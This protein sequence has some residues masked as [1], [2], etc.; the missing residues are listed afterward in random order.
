[1]SLC[2]H[3]RANGLRAIPRFGRDHV[4][5]HG[6]CASVGAISTGV[7]CPSGVT[8]YVTRY[9][10]NATSATPESA[11]QVTT[12]SGRRSPTL[13]RGLLNVGFALAA[14]LLWSMPSS[15][16]FAESTTNQP[17]KRCSCVSIRYPTV[18]SAEISCFLQLL[19]TPRSIA[20]DQQVQKPSDPQ[21][22]KVLTYR[23]P[24]R[25]N[26]LPALRAEPS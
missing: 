19:P 9:L 4:P 6:D 11:Q 22:A 7:A 25:R 3:Y 17:R 23:A 15:R 12:A 8:R 2:R 20:Q 1:V 21:Q 18:S 14:V 13:S 16:S 26:P 24:A 10:R 5:T